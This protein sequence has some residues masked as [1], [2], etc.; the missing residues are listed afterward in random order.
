MLGQKKNVTTH[1]AG[2]V[3]HLRESFQ[4]ALW[5][6]CCVT[7]CD[8][9]VSKLP[10][11]SSPSSSL[12]PS[13][14]AVPDNSVQPV[15]GER[16][17]DDRLGALELGKRSDAVCQASCECTTRSASCTP[18]FALWLAFI[19]NDAETWCAGKLPHWT[20]ST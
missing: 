3:R 1:Q 15:T 19:R 9:P 14:F 11:P 17:A 10:S 2:V 7:G 20:S 18:T 6:V 8:S 13:P 5:S 16:R 12:S 4:P